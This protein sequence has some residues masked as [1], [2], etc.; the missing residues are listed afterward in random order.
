MLSFKTDEQ[1][2]VIT[3]SDQRKLHIPYEDEEYV[4]TVSKKL[5]RNYIVAK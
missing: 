5:E 2:L 3:L 4:H 1:H